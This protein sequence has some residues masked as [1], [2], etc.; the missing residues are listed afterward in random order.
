LRGELILYPQ[1]IPTG[2]PTVLSVK[3]QSPTDE[4]TSADHVTYLVTFSKTVSG[5]DVSDFILATEGAVTGKIASVSAANGHAISVE[6]NAIAGT[7]S[8][9]LDVKNTGTGIV[10]ADSNPLAGGYTSGDIFR[11]GPATGL[12]NAVATSNDCKVFPNPTSGKV[13]IH[14]PDNEPANRMEVFNIQGKQVLLIDHPQN[15]DFDL[16]GFPNGI[17]FVKMQSKSGVYNH[18]IVKHSNP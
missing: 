11:I 15:N 8:L 13:Q 4:N 10:D 9:R 16:S 6:V 12:S 17:Y 18:K 2:M 5:V 3:R 1:W 14:T 7:G